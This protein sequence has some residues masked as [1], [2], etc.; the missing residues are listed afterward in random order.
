MSQ[1]ITDQEDL[2]KLAKKNNSCKPDMSAQI[3]ELAAKPDEKNGLGAKVIL[4]QDGD[5]TVDDRDI[6]DVRE[7]LKPLNQLFIDR[8]LSPV[9]VYCQIVQICSTQQSYYLALT[10]GDIVKI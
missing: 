3:L 1:L 2:Q 10:T 7:V 8:Y 4:R 6:Q 9:S 5:V